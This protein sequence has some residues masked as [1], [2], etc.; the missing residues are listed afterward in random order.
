MAGSAV[1]TTAMPMTSMACAEARTTSASQGLRAAVVVV[2]VVRLGAFSVIVVV[3][4]SRFAQVRALRPRQVL[5]RSIDGV[6][7]RRRW[8]CGS[9]ATWS[10][11]PR[12]GT[13]VERPNG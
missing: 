3:M 9:C 13:L 10:P 11:S 5:D 12:R 6:Y 7:D 1:L 8:I 2:V 4:S